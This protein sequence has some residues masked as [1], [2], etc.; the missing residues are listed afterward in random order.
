MSDL[1][2]AGTA[3]TIVFIAATAL[4][5]A[6]ALGVVLSGNPFRSALWLILNLVSL[7]TF[8]LLLNADFLAAAQV[9]VYAGAV[10]I[11]FLFVIA[12]LGGAADEP[13]RDTPVW[14]L[15]AALIAGGALVA[16]VVLAI[17]SHEF[18]GAP[19]VAGS[20]G[21]AEAVSVPLFS[22]LPAGIRGRIRRAAGRRRRRRRA[23]RAPPGAA[24]AGRGGAV[25][26]AGQASGAGAADA[27]DGRRDHVPGAPRAAQGGRRLMPVGVEYYVGV[28]AILFGI[29]LYGVFIRR[30]PLIVLLSVELMLNSCNLA[31]IAFSRQWGTQD[32]QVFAL[33]VMA[34]A[35]SEVVIGLGLVVA[36]ARRRMELDT[37]SLTAL[38]D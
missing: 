17:T 9:I 24:R 11:M 25:H 2:G 31:L 26:R 6:S 21:S 37:D 34:I 19:D 1:I 38:R 7:A 28:S 32:G 30:S 12:Y 29:G 22:T 3:E 16:E 14:Q 20:F 33:V 18:G 13:S 4:A 35:A 27:G 36:M 5:I 8:Y 10:M 15:A 23:G